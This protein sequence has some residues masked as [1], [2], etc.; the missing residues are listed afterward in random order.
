MKNSPEKEIQIVEAKVQNLKELAT[1][2]GRS[3]LQAYPQNT[4]HQNMELYLKKAF[5]EKEIERQ[6]MSSKSVFFMMKK[7]GENIGY[8]KLRWDRTPNQFGVLRAIELERFYFLDGFKSQ[9][10]GSQF[11]KFCIEFSI[12]NNFEWMWLLVWEENK[13]GLQFYKHKG[14]EIF[15]RKTF[16]FGNDSSDDILMKLKLFDN[17][18]Q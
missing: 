4:D 13:K 11:L 12:K 6:L 5:A 18:F 15:G 10:L 8:A 9:G 2:A 14:F 7:N 17:P 16:H 1:I 3:F